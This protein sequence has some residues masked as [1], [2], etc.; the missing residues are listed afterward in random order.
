[1][2]RYFLTDNTKDL[3]NLKTDQPQQMI[4]VQKYDDKDGQGGKQIRFHLTI[5]SWNEDMFNFSIKIIFFSHLAN[6]IKPFSLNF[7]G[8]SIL[9][10]N[11]FI[12]FSY[13]IILFIIL[14]S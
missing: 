10:F 14:L 13:L 9:S 5:L 7:L 3:T 8:L 6:H 2:P 1:M 11:L 12:S 4:Q